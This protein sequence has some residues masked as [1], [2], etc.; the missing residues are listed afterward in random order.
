MYFTLFV[1]VKHTTNNTTTDRI[2]N[3]FQVCQVPKAD[4]LTLQ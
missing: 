3:L 2:D 4:T 1:L